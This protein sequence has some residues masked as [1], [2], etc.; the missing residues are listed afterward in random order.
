MTSLEIL[1]IVILF[2]TIVILFA[3]LVNCLVYIKKQ[4]ITIEKYKKLLDSEIEFSK[5]R[6]KILL[7][8]FSALETDQF[9]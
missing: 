9:A 3:H 5:E 1:L 7:G 6:E 8:I 4:N 2:G